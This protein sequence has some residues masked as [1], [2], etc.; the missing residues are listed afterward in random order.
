MEFIE[1]YKNKL[2]DFCNN[3]PSDSTKKE[4]NYLLII[5]IQFIVIIFT[6]IILKWL[7][8]K[9]PLTNAKYNYDSVNK[10]I[11]NMRNDLKDL[12]DM[13]ELIKYTNNQIQYKAQNINNK[14]DSIFSKKKQ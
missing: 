12:K 8:K 14:I 2:E 10:I 3:N 7:L 6:I 13:Q 5:G 9:D 4:K 1:T 11:K